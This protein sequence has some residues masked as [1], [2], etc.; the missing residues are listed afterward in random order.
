MRKHLQGIAVTLLLIVG[1][2]ATSI[3]STAHAQSAT[4]G[5]P[6]FVEKGNS[7]VHRSGKWCSISRASAYSESK[8]F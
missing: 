3:L 6:F 8:M 4:L 5:G 2:E 1:T 7:T